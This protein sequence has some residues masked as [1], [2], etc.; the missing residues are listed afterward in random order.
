FSSGLLRPGRALRVVPPPTALRDGRVRV[1]VEV[2]ADPDRLTGRRVGKR[3][4]RLRVR[5]LR[6]RVE[7]ADARVRRAAVGRE[8]H[9]AVVAGAAARDV[10]GPVVLAVVL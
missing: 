1:G 5:R 8:L 4:A 3:D 7:V 2:E 6:S 10:P 9:L